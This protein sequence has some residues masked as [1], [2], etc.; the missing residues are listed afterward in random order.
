MEQIGYSLINA[1]NQEVQFWGDTAGQ[2]A[3][4]PDSI[5]LPN[6]DRVY[7]AKAGERLGD[8]RI[9]ERWLVNGEASIAF[10]GKRVVVSRRETE[11]LLRYADQ[12]LAAVSSAGMLVNVAAQ[13]AEPLYLSVATDADG[14]TDVL[15]LLAEASLGVTSWSWYQSSGTVTISSDQL[16][17]IATAL[18]AFR[19][20]SFA[21]WQSAVSAINANRI[22]SAA[23]I[24]AADWPS[25]G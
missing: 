22:I 15:G 12:K 13:G 9:V 6:G 23:Q 1:N 16:R 19:G 3:G 17:I 25:N 24:D 10:D 2:I 7:G 8:V 21:V 20:K 4:V 11:Q 5:D 14:R 18:A